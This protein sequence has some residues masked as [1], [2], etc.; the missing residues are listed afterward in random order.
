MKFSYRFYEGKFLPIIP[1][2]LTE[3]GKLIQMRAYVDTGA[4]Y[5]LFHAKVAEILGLDVEKGIL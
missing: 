2:S 4:S 3:N 5:S 1:I